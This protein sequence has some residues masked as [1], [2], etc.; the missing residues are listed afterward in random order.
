MQESGKPGMLVLQGLSKLRQIANH[1]AMVLPDY[2]GESG[3]GQD[4]LERIKEVVSE[5]AKTLVFSQFVKHLEAVGSSLQKEGIPYL[6]LDGSTKNR[7]ELVER[8]QSTDQELIFLISL[9]AGG[10]GLNLTAAENVFLL[11]PWWNPAI[12]AQAVDRAHRIGQTKT[13]FSYKFIAQNSIE[14]KIVELQNTKRQLFDE[15]ILEE[16]SFFK[17]LS[18]EDILNLIE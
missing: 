18:T 14:E 2:Q 7:M 11:D 1:P 15:L 16:E 17:S 8:F 10:V 5:G 13:V 3:K 4:I 6:Y 9:K 12:E